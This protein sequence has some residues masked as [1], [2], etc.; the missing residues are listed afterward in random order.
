MRLIIAGPL[1]RGQAGRPGRAVRLVCCATPGRQHGVRYDNARHG[2][3]AGPRGV[4]D[5]RRVGDG[6]HAVDDHHAVRA[7]DSVGVDR[8]GVALDA[9]YA[10]RHRLVLSM[11]GSILATRRP[12][13]TE[14]RPGGGPPGWARRRGPVGEGGVG[15]ATKGVGGHAVVV[16]G[17]AVEGRRRRAARASDPV[18]SALRAPESGPS[19]PPIHVSRRLGEA[20]NWSMPASSASSKP[21]SNTD[22]RSFDTTRVLISGH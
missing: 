1:R 7:V 5:G 18:R 2:A 3:S 16:V 6:E 13:A 21:R 12:V 14:E 20:G 15:G 11:N 9:V 4:S 17:L 10:M 19:S 8:Y 22:Y